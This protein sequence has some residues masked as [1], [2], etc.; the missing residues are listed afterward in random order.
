M[1]PTFAAVLLTLSLSLAGTT[2][3]E[4]TGRSGI[5]GYGLYGDLATEILNRDLPGYSTNRYQPTPPSGSLRLPMGH[6]SFGAT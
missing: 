2:H 1:K 3:A 6:L 5:S 4:E